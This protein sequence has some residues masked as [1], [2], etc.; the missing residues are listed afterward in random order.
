HQVHRT[1]IL[2]IGI[3][4]RTIHLAR[5]CGQ[6]P[7]SNDAVT[8]DCQPVASSGICHCSYCNVPEKRNPAFVRKSAFTAT[9]FCV[10]PWGRNWLSIFLCL[11][12]MPILL[13]A[14]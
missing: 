12:S 6:K 2:T 4:G 8:L 9:S 7:N 14:S 11:S 3:A 13:V 10:P 5:A 1:R